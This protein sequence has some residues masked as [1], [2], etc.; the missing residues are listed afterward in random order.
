MTQPH[1][2]I[3]DCLAHTCT[4]ACA[5]GRH[6]LLTHCLPQASAEDFQDYYD[7]LGLPLE[8][9]GL[10]MRTCDAQGWQALVRVQIREA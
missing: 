5:G 4:E 7:A 2:A 10:T 3:T 8:V 6:A 9:V 1:A